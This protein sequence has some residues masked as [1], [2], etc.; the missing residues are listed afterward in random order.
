MTYRVG[1]V[2]VTTAVGNG[3]YQTPVLPPG[4]ITTMTVSIKIKTTT[5]PG[6]SF[7]TTLTARSTHTTTIRDVV[8][9]IAR[10]V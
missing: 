5:V 6:N 2:G 10:R 1:G 4:G 9:F 8:K 7:T 3:T